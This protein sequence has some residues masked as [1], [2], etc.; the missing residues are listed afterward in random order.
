V[1]GS[2]HAGESFAVASETREEGESFAGGNEGVVAVDGP[3]EASPFFLR[4]I[5]KRRHFGRYI[6]VFFSFE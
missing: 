1:T 5:R 3:I 6:E 2:Y 4:K